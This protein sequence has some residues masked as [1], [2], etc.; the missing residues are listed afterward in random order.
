MKVLALTSQKGGSGKTT[1]AGHIAVE[2]DRAGCGPVAI[3]DTDPQG[4]LTDWWNER[5]AASPSFVQAQIETLE[6]D[7][8]RARDHGFALVVIDT[9][10]AITGTIERV[11]GL[12]D[13]VAV[14]TRPSPHDLR[15][16]GTTIEMVES[17]GKPLVF[18]VNAAN[19]RARITS[20]AAIVL[21]QHGTVAPVTVHQRTDFAAAMIDGR[22]VMEIERAERS[23]DEIVQLWAYLNGRL[24]GQGHTTLMPASFANLPGGHSQPHVTKT[25]ITAASP[26][27][28]PA[29]MPASVATDPAREPAYAAY[30][31]APSGPGFATG[32]VPQPPSWSRV[33]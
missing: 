5:E 11:I 28:A 3:V 14:P 18:V 13:L 32:G 33:P 30:D 9:P 25:P 26:A 24:N 7:L 20:E 8:Q 22:T 6:A 31:Y 16:V 27:P 4:S 29:P 15:A 12:A 19:P 23:R 17:Q 1:L 10:P 2:A 21:S